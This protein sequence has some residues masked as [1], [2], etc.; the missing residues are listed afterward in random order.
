MSFY[1][2]LIKKSFKKSFIYRAN[3]Y[4]NILAAIIQLVIQISIWM[5]LYGT[6]TVHNGI[7]ISAMITFV[8]ITRIVMSLTNSTVGGK[9]SE[10]INQGTIAIDFVKPINMRWAYF[11]ED[12]GSN[13]YN[14]LFTITPICIIT[15]LFIDI[16]IPKDFSTTILFIISI[17]LGVILMYYIHY[18]LGLCCFWLESCWGIDFLKQGLM[19]LFGGTYVPLWYYPTI[20]Y[21]ISVFLPFRY[22]CFDPIQMYIQN[23]S[24]KKCMLVLGCQFF[25]ILILI[26]VERVVYKLARKRLSIVG[27]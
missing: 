9:I 18:V 15:I 20:L 25:W 3:S 24:P 7:S 14:L 10:K 8:V 6:N 2:E 13:L 19:E 22:I 12:L 26:I 1:F 11:A 21:N 23:Y 5:S 4:T 17:V 27:G 16:I